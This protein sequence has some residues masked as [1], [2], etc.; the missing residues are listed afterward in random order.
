MEDT[1]RV[2]DNAIKALE[3]SAENRPDSN[4]Q[5]L[6]IKDS[7]NDK[8]KQMQNEHERRVTLLNNKLNALQDQN[9]EL[10]DQQSRNMGS[11]AMEISELKNSNEK[12]TEE[13]K[14]FKK[15]N[16]DLDNEKN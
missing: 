8:L 7:F 2:H 11:S 14:C 16:A 1:R 15:L 10:L 4:K 9:E 5:L 13:N 12:L 3:G 6:E